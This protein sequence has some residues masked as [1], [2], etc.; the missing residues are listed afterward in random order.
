MK[1]RWVINSDKLRYTNPYIQVV[2]W[3]I[4]PYV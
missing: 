1:W 4:Q 2:D 3:T